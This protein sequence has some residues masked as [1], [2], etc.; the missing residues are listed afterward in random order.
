M[1]GSKSVEFASEGGAGRSHVV[2]Q[3]VCVACGSQSS[4]AVQQSVL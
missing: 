3:F 1:G 4:G 2:G